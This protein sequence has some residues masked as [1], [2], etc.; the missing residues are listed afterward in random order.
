MNVGWSEILILLLSSVAL[1]LAVAAGVVVA[2]RWLRAR[3]D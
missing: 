3:G 2:R 1:V